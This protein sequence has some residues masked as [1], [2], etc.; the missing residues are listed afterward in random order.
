MENQIRKK[1]QNS[2]R[3]VIKVGTNKKKNSKF[4]KNSYKS[5]YI[6]FDLC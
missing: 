2:K 5:R 1:I 3:I 6:Y 4:Q